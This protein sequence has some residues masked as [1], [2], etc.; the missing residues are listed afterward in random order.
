MEI[1]KKGN[2]LVFKIITF[3]AVLAIICTCPAVSANNLRVDLSANGNYS[4]IQDAI[5]AANAE[6][7]IFVN[8]GNYTENLKIDKQVRIWSDS[9]KPGDTVIRG[10]D[11]TK[12]TVEI[13]GDKVSFSGFDVEGSNKAQIS[14][15]GSKYC[16]I[17]NNWLQ[18]TE[19]G[20]LLTNSDNNTITDNN[21]TLNKVGIRLEDSNSNTIQDNIIAYNYVFGISNEAGVTNFIYNNFFK[22]SENVEEKAINAENIWQSPLITRQNIIKGPYIGGNYWA[23]I[24]GT[25]YSETAIDDNNNGIC[26]SP[27]N[28]TGGGTDRFPLFPKN[29]KAVINLENKLNFTATTYA[30]VLA[31][32]KNKAKVQTPVNTTNGTKKSSEEP[33]FGLEAALLATVAVYFLRRN[34]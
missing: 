30:Q 14:L 5:N 1:V 16:F 32:E 6:D 29:P 10:A 27:Y 34:R 20:I 26:D 2:L 28:L 4:S 9:R 3:A 22:N 18:R 7:T 19:F 21:I 33:G 31:D 13:S 11:P 15:T 8:P 12:S 25:G 17:N 24:N 23:N